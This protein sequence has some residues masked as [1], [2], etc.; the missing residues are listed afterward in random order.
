[1]SAW[2]LFF[3]VLSVI[4]ECQ[5]LQTKKKKKLKKPPL[6]LFKA[7]ADNTVVSS[8]F[9]TSTVSVDLHFYHVSMLCDHLN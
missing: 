3:F 7:V 1:M 9:L 2:T 6:Y 5:L 4:S 8:L